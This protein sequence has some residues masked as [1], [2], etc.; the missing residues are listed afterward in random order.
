M[1]HSNVRR[2]LYAA[3]GPITT[4]LVGFGL[5]TETTAVAIGGLATETVTLAYAVYCAIRC[6]APVE[7]TVVYGFLTALT[8]V[9][10]VIGFIDG[11]H[12]ELLVPAVMGLLGVVAALV[13]T[14][15][16]GVATDD[17]GHRHNL[18]PAP[19]PNA[20][21]GSPPLPPDL[22]PGGG[23]DGISDAQ[24]RRAA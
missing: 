4:A 19:D 23:A 15:T 13:N 16:P 8:G 17:P 6:R 3:V 12:A 10:T 24:P 7:R 22:D 14:G 1:I 9:A 20:P 2:N 11:F 18:G 5:V 21:P